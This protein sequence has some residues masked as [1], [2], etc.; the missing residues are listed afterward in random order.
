MRPCLRPGFRIKLRQLSGSAPTLG[1]IVLSTEKVPLYSGQTGLS[2]RELAEQKAIKKV[3][4]DQPHRR[5]DDSR[6]I[7]SAVGRLCKHYRWHETSYHAG[8]MYGEIIR[9]WRR[10]NGFHVV[11]YHF[12]G[13]PGE[14]I[15]P[16]TKLIYEKKKADADSELT[17]VKWNL[18]GVMVDLC[19]WEKDQPHRWHGAI[20]NGLVRLALRFGMRQMFHREEA[21]ESA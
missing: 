6:E 7:E 21:L 9:Q 16:E 5:G 14:E 11:G 17:P 4:L 13:V 2:Q 10:A 19:Y 8:I 20:A 15:T 3:V 18:P 12:D 1:R